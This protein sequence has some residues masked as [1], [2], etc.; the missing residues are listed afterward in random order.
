MVTIELAPEEWDFADRV[1]QLRLRESRNA[2]RFAG[3]N[4]TRSLREREFH[5]RLGAA[6]ELAVAKWAGIP[7]EGTVNTFTSTPDVG[8]FDVRSTTRIKTGCLIVR[9]ED[10]IE[11]PFV[12]VLSRGW[13]GN[14][15]Y[16]PGWLFGHEVQ[17]RHIKQPHNHPKA[18]FVPQADL[19]PME[20]WRDGRRF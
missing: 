5:E 11:R 14:P 1:G 18:W 10:H 8:P 9:D 4:Q 3:R 6:A 16:L 15:L 13:P 2:G 20:E 12:L 19:H 7:Y 17:P